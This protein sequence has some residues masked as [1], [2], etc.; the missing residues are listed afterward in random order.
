MLGTNAPADKVRSFPHTFFHVTSL[1]HTRCRLSK[2]IEKGL[3]ASGNGYYVTIDAPLEAYWQV[4]L[5][6]AALCARQGQI[7]DIEP[8]NP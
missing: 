1:L 7:G 4:L 6:R 8:L 3:S 2:V 5:P